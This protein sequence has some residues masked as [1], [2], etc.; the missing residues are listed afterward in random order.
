MTAVAAQSE[1]S[2]AFDLWAE[3][4][5]RQPNPVLGLEQRY[6]SRLL[7]SAKGLKVL[8]AGCGTG[9]WLRHFAAD[10][11]RALIGVDTSQAMLQRA[12]LNAPTA[13]LHAASADTLPIRG[14]TIDIAM[15]SFLTSYL[16]DLPRFATE[17]HRVARSDARVFLSDLHPHTAAI[18]NWKRVFTANGMQHRLRDHHYSIA[19]I[20]GYFERAGFAV[21]ALLEPGFESPEQA[22]FAAGDKLE[23]FDS[24][25][26]RPAIYILEL[27]KCGL[28]HSLLH[29]FAGRSA[30]RHRST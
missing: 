16:D 2:A 13:V 6:L 15:A 22:I 14:S 17:I 12:A 3:V 18:L 30:R 21:R 28:R 9:R 20:I 8:D 19:E 24:L 10:S 7:P 5:D 25:A 27:Q 23:A 29:A 1:C 4:Y 11:P 26:G